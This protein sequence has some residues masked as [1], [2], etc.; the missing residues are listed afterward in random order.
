MTEDRKPETPGMAEVSAKLSDAAMNDQH[1]LDL[2]RQV[3]ERISFLD[4][5]EPGKDHTEEERGQLFDKLADMECEIVEAPAHTAAGIAV[6]LRRLRTRHGDQA[7]GGAAVS[8]AADAPLVCDDKGF[9]TVLE[10]LERLGGGSTAAIPPSVTEPEDAVVALRQ[11][12]EGVRAE[13]DQ[14]KIRD[15]N[16]SNDPGLQEDGR[17][18]G[19]QRNIEESIANTPT[20]TAAGVA[21]KL[22]QLQ[23]DDEIFD[24]M[25]SWRPAAFRTALEALDREAVP[26]GAASMAEDPVLA[27]KREWETRYKAL[28]EQRE[29]GDDSDEARQ[30]FFDRLQETEDQIL[31]TQATTSAGIAVKLILWAHQHCTADEVSG[32]SWNGKSIQGCPL[33]LGRQ[34]VLSA[35]LDLER[36]ART[37]AVVDTPPAEDTALFDALAEYDRLVAIERDLEG[38]AD[39]F[40]EGTPEAKEATEAYEAAW[41]EVLAA[42]KV[43]QAIPATTQAG[44]FARLQAT[45]R[46]MTGLGESEIYD[47]EWSVIKADVQRITGEA[48]S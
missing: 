11:R 25:S 16:D 36:L 7:A 1:L 34:P 19:V 45:D 44:L 12:W 35:L 28:D 30:P 38:R 14:L 33:D 32:L 39:V 18:H 41:D 13:R 27:L 3:L 47:T 9:Q 23:R 31:R 10:T 2:E 8:C 29:T 48:R 22:R 40:R 43:A 24:G 5:T 37:P 4:R 42:W 20:H 6:K 26:I 21:V 46:F 15:D 17:L